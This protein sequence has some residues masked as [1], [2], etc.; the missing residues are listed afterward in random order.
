MASKEFEFLTKVNNDYKKAFEASNP[1]GTMDWYSREMVRYD[2]IMEGKPFP[3]FLKPYFVLQSHRAMFEESTRHI[4]SGLETIGNA[5]LKDNYD[6]DGQIGFIGVKDRLKELCKYTQGYPWNQCCV[7]NDLFY[8]PDTG[9]M[10]YLEFNCGDPSGMGWNDVM[11]DMFKLLPAVKELEKKYAFHLDYLL[12]THEKAFIRYYQAFCEHWGYPIKEK[13]VIA[14]TLWDESTVW[15]DFDMFRKIYNGKGYESY[16]ADPSDYKYDGKTLTLHGVPIDLIYRDAITDITND[17]FWWNCQALVQAYKE[18]AVCVVNPPQAG[19][20]DFKTIPAI[21]TD[22]KYREYFTDEQWD[23]YEKHVPWTRL[24]R[25][26]TTNLPDGK[27]GDLIKFLRANKSKLV[28]KPN[29]DYGGHGILIGPE[30]EQEVWDERIDVTLAGGRWNAVQELVRIPQEEFPIMEGNKFVGFER[31]NVNIN[32]WSH[33]GEFAGAFNRAAKGSLV[34][35]HA[36]GGIMPVFFVE[37][38]K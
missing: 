28:L 7:R 21:M 2:M 31:R 34:N 18:G 25:E 13:P 16:V 1:K 8:H 12:E 36:G 5:Y 27:K 4:M 17:E 29:D 15:S 14:F 3:T 22:E 24:V 37:K 9:E 19:S 10:K 32:F 33:G 30:T 26:G 38:K 35:V 11:L 20:C 23:S 6:F